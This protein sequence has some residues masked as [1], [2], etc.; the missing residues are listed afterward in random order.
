MPGSEPAS[1]VFIFTSSFG[2][3]YCKHSKS[4]LPFIC[5]THVFNMDI[6]PLSGA[7]ENSHHRFGLWLIPRSEWKSDFSRYDLNRNQMSFKN[8]D[9]VSSFSL[10]L[11]F[12]FFFPQTAFTLKTRTQT[13]DESY[14]EYVH[15]PLPW[16]SAC[17]RCSNHS[18]ALA[19][20][21][22][23]A[24]NQELTSFLKSLNISQ[25]VWIANKVVT[26]L[27]SRLILLFVTLIVFPPTHSRSKKH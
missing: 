2:W 11:T 5:F 26:H 10:N 13:Y 19:V 16:K 3:L 7:M 1:R 20:V 9:T 12:F 21:S 17:E 24:E 4:V 23:Q 25:P 22:N 14:Y 8:Q 18:G 27:T 15:V 6:K